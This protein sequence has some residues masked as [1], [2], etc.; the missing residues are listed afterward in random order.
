MT[1]VV[2]GSGDDF[3]VLASDGLW[4]VM[5]DQDAVDC[6][7]ITLQANPVSEGGG[8]VCV[9]GGWGVMRLCSAVGA[10][11]A[12]AVVVAWSVFRG[13][14]GAGLFAQAK[15]GGGL[16]LHSTPHHMW[17]HPPPPLL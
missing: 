14:E 11:V 1:R 16:N 12:V 7:R 6:V 10:I 5:S 3:V 4:D 15:G 8:G 17:Y 9:C 13:R 2:P